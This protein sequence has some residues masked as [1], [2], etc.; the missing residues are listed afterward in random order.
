MTKPKLFVII[1]IV[2]LIVLGS[3]GAY[4]FYTKYNEVT[5]K[6]AGNSSQDDTDATIAK[7]AS[8][9]EVPAGETPS[10]ATVKDVEKIVDQPFFTRAQNGDKVVLYPKAQIA[11]LYRPSTGKVVEVSPITATPAENISI[12]I[13]NGTDTAGLA[14]TA[15]NKLAAKFPELKIVQKLNAS[16]ND[17]QKTLVY[18]ISGQNQELA[19]NIAGELGGEIVNSIP[20]GEKLPVDTG[21]KILII[22]GSDFK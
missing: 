2:I 7:V 4:Y 16:K 15:A 21:I 20:E 1:G 12:S 11:I 6:V 14:S 22:L 13:L 10:V 8:L 9:V 17:Y 18:D 19:G 3:G 5:K